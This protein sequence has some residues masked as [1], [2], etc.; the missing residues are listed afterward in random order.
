MHCI[1]INVKPSTKLQALQS[2]VIAI[3][4]KLMIKILSAMGTGLQRKEVSSVDHLGVV[5]S[6]Y[7]SY[8]VLFI[9]R[10]YHTVTRKKYEIFTHLCL[11]HW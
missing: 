3:S 7:L 4:L 10:F 5:R 11:R 8:F 9:A 2:T 6:N 1:Q